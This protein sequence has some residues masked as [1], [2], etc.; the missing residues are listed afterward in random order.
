MLEC[1]DTFDLIGYVAG[2]G[3]LG[4]SG[5]LQIGHDADSGGRWGWFD[6]LPCER[7]GARRGLG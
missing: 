3:G 2:D 6:V 1:S 4:S 5:V 7:L